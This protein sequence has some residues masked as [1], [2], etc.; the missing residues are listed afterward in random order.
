MNYVIIVLYCNVIIF[1]VCWRSELIE[2]ATYIANKEY[3]YRQVTYIVW[4]HTDSK[5]VDVFIKSFLGTVATFQLE[6]SKGNE[7]RI[8]QKLIKYKQTVF[9]ATKPEEFEFFL[10]MVR[11]KIVAS[12]RVILIVTVPVKSDSVLTKLTKIA[13][14]NDV[15]FIVILSSDSISNRTALTSYNPFGQ[16]KCDNYKPIRLPDNQSN[17]F[18]RNFANFQRCPVRFTALQ[19]PPFFIFET[20]NGSVTH[21]GGIDG[22]VLKLILERLNASMNIVSTAHDGIGVFVNGTATGA[23]GD[24]VKG[25]AD[26]MALAI[27]QSYERH[28]VAQLTYVYATLD[29]VW[30]APNRREISAWAKIL[31][32]LFTTTTPFLVLSF[33]VI[34][35]SVMLVQRFGVVKEQKESTFLNIVYQTLAL[36]L[37]QSIDFLT[38]YWLKNSVFVLW[39]WFC[40]IVRVVYQ[41]DLVDGFQR[42]ILE[43]HLSTLEEAISTVEGYGGVP[44]FLEFYRNTSIEKNYKILPLNQ[45]PDYIKHI[46]NGKRYL[47]AV[48]V[49]FVKY[50]NL[51]LQI[52]DERVTRIPICFFT[53]PRWPAAEEFNRVVVRVAEAGFVEKILRDH[54]TLW[55]SHSNVT[56]VGSVK[57]I[58]FSTV[59]A[60]F[61]G[62]IV[63]CCICS[64]VFSLELIFHK[65]KSTYK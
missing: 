42:T 54:T 9:F 59:S 29:V 3:E 44:G 22:E 35:T 27:I 7:L 41:S 18:G 62:L 53:R 34:I 28:A 30:C 64:V 40:L 48:D 63:M 4:G 20:K 17:Y 13:W 21:I 56:D 32:P 50:L 10:K 31:L 5:Y 23:F 16:G 65:Y 33:V 1:N 57:P 58:D 60:C 37:G 8:F 2:K 61:Y 49:L 51:S 15:G 14:K 46:A 11:D 36:F 12:I 47:M 43:P 24:L 38:K 39:I 45:T 55:L 19:F 25:I 26:T 6:K 52:L